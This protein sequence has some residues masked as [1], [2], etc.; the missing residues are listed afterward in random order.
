MSIYIPRGGDFELPNNPVP[1]ESI[2]AIAHEA[3][4]WIAA[5]IPFKADSK[6]YRPEM[7]K[8]GGNCYAQAIGGVALLDSWKVSSGI[9]LTGYHAHIVLGKGKEIRFL[10]PHT[11]RIT[12]PEQ[13]KDRLRG[14]NA[15]SIYQK[16]LPK[17]LVSENFVNYYYHENKTWRSLKATAIRGATTHIRSTMEDPHVVVDAE[18]GI[19]MLLACGDLTRYAQSKPEKFAEEYYKRIDMIPDFKN[20]IYQSSTL[21]AFITV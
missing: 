1:N 14:G 19:D 6:I 3:L 21:R 11:K 15:A 16:T 7:A 9:I 17:A 18:R 12:T 20:P 13:E 10:D 5:T 2:D 8:N 4:D